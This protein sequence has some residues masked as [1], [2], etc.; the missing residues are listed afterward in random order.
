MEPKNE[1][2]KIIVDTLIEFVEG[3]E[4]DDKFTIKELVQGYCKSD[5]PTHMNMAA[6]YKQT[7]EQL[8]IRDLAYVGGMPEG[9]GLEDVVWY[10][11]FDNGVYELY[12]AC[13]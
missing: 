6:V 8:L 11:K 12:K 10:R 1:V 2:V 4:G 9:A 3:K 5:S 13:K 7:Y